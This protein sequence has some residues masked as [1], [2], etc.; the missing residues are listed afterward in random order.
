[1]SRL[2]ALAVLLWA[3]AVQASCPDWSE[4]RAERELTALGRQLQRWD[5][6]YHVHGQSLVDDELYDQVRNRFHQW[7]ACFA[8][9]AMPD[10]QPLAGSAGPALHPVV[11][12]GLAKLTET[13]EV[14]AWIAPRKDLWVQPKVDG[15]AVTLLYR[16]G[17]LVQAISRGDGHRGQ[18]WTARAL[19]LPAIP[20]HLARDDELIL[21]GELYWRLDGHIQA[22]AGSAGARSKMA[23]AMARQTLDAQT[24]AQIGLFV[25]DW[26]NGPAQMQARLE[27]LAALGFGASVELTQPIADFQQ[28]RHWREHWYRRPLP[29][30]SDG[31]VLRQGQ[32]PSGVRWQAQPPHWAAAWKYPLRT[33]LAEVRDVQFTIGRSGRITPL[34]QLQPVL[35]DDRRITRVSLGS[36]ERWRSEDI[37]PGDQVAIRLAGMTTP[38]LDSVIWRARE[39]QQIEAPNAAAYHWQ[40]CWQAGPGCD[41]QFVARLVWLSGKEGLDLPR[42]GP[43][44]WMALVDAGAFSGLLGWLNLDAVR[45]Q[46]VPGIGR[47]EAEALMASYRLARERSFATWLRAIG[48]PPSGEADIEA[49]W[50]T[51]ARK[52]ATQWQ[53]EPGVGAVRAHRLRAFFREPEVTSLRERLH[54]AG[55]AGF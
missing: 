51:L 38:Q 14:Q 53:A 17:R 21:Q 52:S 29:F 7:Q 42:L 25:W 23:G 33:T 48:L 34:L 54:A 39:R 27:G 47:I 2:A 9:T 28:A 4:A 26:P 18:D 45:L 32:R 5:E 11:Q 49:D 13:A 31:V 15:V 16:S 37:Q 1:M 43:G 10:T 41:Q 3:H 35:L 6:A 55:I 24:A 50:D 40:S 20:R 30:A 44:T 8:R 46:Q 36:L 19:Q 12:T 22:D